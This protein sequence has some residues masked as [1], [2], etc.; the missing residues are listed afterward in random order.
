MSRLI[1]LFISRRPISGT[2]AMS[3][4]SL[5]LASTRCAFPISAPHYFKAFNFDNNTKVA[6]RDFVHQNASFHVRCDME[7]SYLL[8]VPCH[9]LLWPL[10]CDA[11]IWNCSSHFF[12]IWV[13]VLRSCLSSSRAWFKDTSIPSFQ[14]ISC[15]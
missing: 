1:C 9:L 12:S 14:N 5:L 11:L 13:L 8:M 6:G 15:L 4:F 3:V 2:M 7:A 10:G